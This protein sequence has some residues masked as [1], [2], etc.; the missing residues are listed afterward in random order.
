MRMR[1]FVFAEYDK[2]NRVFLTHSGM[3][4][5]APAC[6]DKDARVQ[7]VH[8]NNRNYASING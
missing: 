7:A 1:K 3:C 5:E 6:G 8:S 2:A 4:D